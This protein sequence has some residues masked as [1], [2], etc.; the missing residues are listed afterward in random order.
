MEGKI[1]L[2][3]LAKKITLYLVQKNY[4]KNSVQKGGIAGMAGYL[5]HTNVLSEN[6]REARENERDIAVIWLD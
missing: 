1:F 3:V 4:V 6:I 5:K 2:A